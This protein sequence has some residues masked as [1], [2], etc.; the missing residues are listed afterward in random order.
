MKYTIGFDKSVEFSLK[1]Q[2]LRICD[3]ANTHTH[4][5]YAQSTSLNGSMEC[6]LCK[7]GN[8][9]NESDAIMTTA[10]GCMFRMG[11]IICSSTKDGTLLLQITVGQTSGIVTVVLAN[12]QTLRGRFPNGFGS[13]D[14]LLF[15]KQAEPAIMAHFEVEGMK[16]PEMSIQARPNQMQ[17]N[18]NEEQL[19]CLLSYL[20]MLKVAADRQRMA[21]AAGQ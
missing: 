18:L 4:T 3:E 19:L 15:T 11:K 21:V 5:I 13:C 1:R 14:I 17:V 2:K 16:N 10:G 20:Y 9:P 7:I 12:G 8:T 6:F